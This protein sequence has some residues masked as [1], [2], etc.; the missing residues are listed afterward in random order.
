MKKLEIGSGTYPREGYI[1]VDIRL[2]PETNVVCDARNLPFSDEIFDEV[3]S[4]HVIEHFSWRETETILKEWVRV[5]KKGGKI[6]IQCPNIAYLC[7]YYSKFFKGEIDKPIWFGPESD[8]FGGQ[9]HEF[10]YHKIGFSYK[11]LL[12]KLE[13]V[14]ICDI[15]DLTV[16]DGQHDKQYQLHIEGIKQ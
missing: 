15:S 11:T 16:V 7:E 2:L 5:L 8:I 3:L 9:K 14:G 6:S 1:H 13:T 10:D 4:K 12:K